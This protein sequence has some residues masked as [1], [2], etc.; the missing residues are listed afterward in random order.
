MAP[1]ALANKEGAKKSAKPPSTR[2]GASLFR[3]GYALAKDGGETAAAMRV[4]LPTFPH[5]SLIPQRFGHS[6]ASSSTVSESISIPPDAPGSFY[7]RWWSDKF[8]TSGTVGKHAYNC[9]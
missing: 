8:Y 4:S 2:K 1:C 7:N 3:R 5:V 6:R 9:R